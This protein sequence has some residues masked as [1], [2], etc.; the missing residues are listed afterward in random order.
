MIHS[1][2]VVDHA[3]ERNSSPANHD[4]YL[5]SPAVDTVFD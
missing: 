2:P 3:N 4:L 1:A 5:A